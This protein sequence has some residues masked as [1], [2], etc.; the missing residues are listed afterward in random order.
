M[1][2][3]EKRLQLRFR[4]QRGRNSVGL[5]PVVLVM[6]QQFPNHAYLNVRAFQFPDLPGLKW[7]ERLSV[8]LQHATIIVVKPGIGKQ[9]RRNSA[10]RT[11]RASPGRPGRHRSRTPQCPGSSG[12]VMRQRLP[13]RPGGKGTGWR[14]HERARVWR[15]IPG[16]ASNPAAG[17]P[18]LPRCGKRRWPG[19]PVP[20]GHRGCP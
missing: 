15:P 18:W 19:R 1:V 11:P 5:L 20:A 8:L 13:T 12:R 10:P 2:L 9:H 7:C 17:I 14:G 4:R 16:R 3:R 6:D